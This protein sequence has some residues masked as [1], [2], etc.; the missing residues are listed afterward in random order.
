[1]RAT[2]AAVFAV[3]VFA[4]PAVAKPRLQFLG[5][6]IVPTGTMYRGTPV[7]GLS[8]IT[9]DARRGAYYAVSDDPA[10]VRYYTVGL[11][12]RDGRLVQRRR[13]LRERH[14][15]AG[16]RQRAVRADRDRPGRPRADEG[17]RAGADVRGLREHG[18]RPVR[19]ALRPR[20]PVPS[21]RCRSRSRSS[22]RRRAAC[23]RTWGSRARA[24]AAT[25][26]SSPPRT[27]SS[28][29]ARPRRSRTAARPGS[30]A[31]TCAAGGSSASGSTRPTPS[32]SRPSRRPRSRSTASSS[33]CR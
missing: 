22:P 24:C 30:C 12:L 20:R 14:Q 3:L 2:F 18:G 26:C 16:A 23:A 31:T 15:P 8:S 33:S 28:R 13:P 10:A 7:G 11:D 5:Q 25:T 1:M 4:A 6:A 21:G 19:A 9:Y 32:R 29:T 27:R 17:P